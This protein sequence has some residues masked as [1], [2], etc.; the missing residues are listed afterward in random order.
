MRNLFAKDWHAYVKSF[1]LCSPKFFRK[2]QDSARRQALTPVS[3]GAPHDLDARD[4][5]RLCDWS[6]PVVELAFS[7]RRSDLGYRLRR[8]IDTEGDKALFRIL[9]HL[10]QIPRILP[11]LNRSLDK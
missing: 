5:R 4:I 1:S 10:R 6:F 9:R 3:H 7:P 2:L 8:G 11:L